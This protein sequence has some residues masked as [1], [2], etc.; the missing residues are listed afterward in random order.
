MLSL[1]FKV[2]RFSAKWPPFKVISS[3]SLLPHR[4]WLGS[5]YSQPQRFHT[6]Q[7]KMRTAVLV[8]LFTGKPLALCRPAKYPHARAGAPVKVTSAVL[9]SPSTDMKPSRNQ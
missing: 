7:K 3:F 4:H 5:S 8:R 6:R 9:S 2:M 1:I